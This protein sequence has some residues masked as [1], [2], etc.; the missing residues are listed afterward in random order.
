MVSILSQLQCDNRTY[1]TRWSSTIAWI[2]QPTAFCSSVRW[3]LRSMPVICFKVSIQKWE[4]AISSPSYIIHGTLPLE[5]NCRPI[6]FY[7]WNTQTCKHETQCEIFLY[8]E[9]HYGNVTWTFYQIRKIAGWACAGN[10]G[11][12]SLPTDFKGNGQLAIPA[13]ITASASRTCRDACRDR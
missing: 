12:L 6:E 4:S 8:N 3:A 13:C 11:T 7:K 10:P 2:V 1:L 5:E 9:Y